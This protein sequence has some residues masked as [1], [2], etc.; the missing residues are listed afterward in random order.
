MGKEI[1][2]FIDQ[3]KETNIETRYSAGKIWVFNGEV[4]IHS[5][6]VGAEKTF[7]VGQPVYDEDG[8]LLGYLGISIFENLDYHLPEETLSKG[9]NKIPCEYWVICLPT[10]YCKNGVKVFTYW[11][12]KERLK[13]NE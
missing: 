12:N 10:K 5:Q 13:E 4:A 9:I 8:N 2:K 3:C 7:S 6:Q 1:K 11:Q